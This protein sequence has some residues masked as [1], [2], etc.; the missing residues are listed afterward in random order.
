MSNI[1]LSANQVYQRMC[2][3]V[4]NRSSDV[5]ITN[6]YQ[7]ISTY[8][9]QELSLLSFFTLPRLA[10]KVYRKYVTFLALKQIK[11]LNLCYS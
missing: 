5:N 6:I 9:D 3:W 8:G 1:R 2:Y 10:V 7:H 4:H 11:F